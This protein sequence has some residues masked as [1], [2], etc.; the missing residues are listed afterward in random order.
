MKLIDTEFNG[1]S[2]ELSLK[3]RVQVGIG[4]KKRKENEILQLK[5][6]GTVCT[7]NGPK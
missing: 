7:K 4:E 5:G 6:R 1:E 2:N 3:D